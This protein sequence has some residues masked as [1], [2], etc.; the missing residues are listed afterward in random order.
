[1]KNFI[2]KDSIFN[3]I[4][5]NL[6]HHFKCFINSLK[7]LF[8]NP[9]KYFL[10]I[11]PISVCISLVLV[12]YSFIKNIEINL[13]NDE[14]KV[15]IFLKD[16]ISTAEID[17]IKKEIIKNDDIITFNYYDEKE[18]LELYLK[19]NKGRKIINNENYNPFP[20]TIIIERKVSKSMFN[21]SKIKLFLENNKFIDSFNSNDIFLKRMNFFKNILLNI[22]VISLFF[23]FF[24]LSFFINYYMKIEISSNKNKIY[25]YSLL[26]ARDSYIRREYIYLP[27]LLGFLSF[28]LGYVFFNQTL[29]WQSISGLFLIVFGV[30]LVNVF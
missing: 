1:M 18:S 16:N 26:G 19:I 17:S 9:L 27:V 4:F 10:F 21:N 24:I 6:L 7:K 11:I 20:K 25:I 8:N 12:S 23:L 2:L 29:T 15:I 22:L 5:V 13:K 3:S 30:I 14:E 28:I